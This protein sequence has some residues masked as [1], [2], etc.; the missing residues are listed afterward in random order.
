MKHDATTV[1]EQA[2][3]LI[4]RAIALANL[5]GGLRGAAMR[6]ATVAAERTLVARKSAT[7][8]QAHTAV[9]KSYRWLERSGQ[10]LFVPRT[11]WIDT[12]VCLDRHRRLERDKRS[13]PGVKPKRCKPSAVGCL[14]H[15]TDV[16]SGMKS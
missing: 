10:A 9:V 1:H 13:D 14:E 5:R 4:V 15:G 16:C 8:S 12:R 7:A 11:G 3:E 2:V 6:E